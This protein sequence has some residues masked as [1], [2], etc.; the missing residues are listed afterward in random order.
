MTRTDDIGWLFERNV[1]EDGNPERMLKIARSVGMT[2]VEVGY[3][4]VDGDDQE[5]RP[6]KTVSFANDEPVFVY[7]SMNLCRWLLRRKN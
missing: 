6:E 4:S 5:L 2:C 3:T 1:F 7:G